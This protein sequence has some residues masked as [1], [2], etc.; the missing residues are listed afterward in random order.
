MQRTPGA[1]EAVFLLARHAFDDLGHRRFEWKCNT[2][3]ARSKR[4]AERFG[5]TYEGLFRQHMVV[6]VLK[7]RDTA[8]Y[9]MIDSEWP[10][11]RSAFQ[12]WLAAGNFDAE[13]QQRHRLEA[14]VLK[15]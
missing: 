6:G 11:C 14:Q 5:F 10:A 4:A 3:N 13:G 7:S 15:R 12:H 8:W 1:T 9:A 2:R